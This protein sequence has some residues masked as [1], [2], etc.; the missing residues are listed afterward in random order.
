MNNLQGADVGQLRTLS[1]H[2]QRASETLER[3]LAEI[4]TS[5]ERAGWAGP[6]AQRFRGDWEVQLRRSLIDTRQGLATAA[7]VLARNA[8]EQERASAGT[9][10]SSSPG[11]RMHASPSAQNP[12]PGTAPVGNQ[13]GLLNGALVGKLSLQEWQRGILD[14][15]DRDEFEPAAKIKLAGGQHVIGKDYTNEHGSY[16]VGLKSEGDLYVG[17]DGLSADAS[18]FAG[19][20]GELHGKHTLGEHAELRGNVSAEAGVLADASGTLGVDGIGVDAKAF[21]GAK[22][23]ASGGAEIAGVYAGTKVEGW[24]G[25]G[26]EGKADFGWQDGTLKVDLALGAGL[27]LGGKVGLDFE[28]DPA[29]V[30][31]SLHSAGQNIWKFVR[32]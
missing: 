21:A 9:D 27:G 15:K 30:A 5:L 23:E 3:I 19:V 20:R 12:E 4:S 7:A 26:A 17:T 29:E 8:D 22:A 18:V 6:D 11:L 14:S 13:G 31:D 1:A 2:L 32:G 16:V 10:G 25:V 28:I 24:A